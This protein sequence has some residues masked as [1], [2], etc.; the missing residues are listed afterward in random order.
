SAARDVLQRNLAE[1]PQPVARTKAP[2]V[3]VRSQRNTT[4]LFGAGK[5]DQIPDHILRS[6]A[7]AQ[8]KEGQVSGRVPPVGP[9]KVGRFGWRG[10][11]EHLHDF[12]LGACANELGLEVPGNAQPIDP[13]R[14]AYRSPGLDLT[15]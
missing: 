13:L 10:Q 3:L 5:I 1:Q 12:V 2:V 4:A 9:D 6:L 15:S 14:P 11:M 7:T 8:T